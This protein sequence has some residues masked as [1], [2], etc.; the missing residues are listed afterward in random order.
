[1]NTPVRVSWRPSHLPDFG[2]VTVSADRGRLRDTGEVFA[3]HYTSPDGTDMVQVT[4][5][6]EQGFAAVVHLD[7]TLADATA[8]VGV[9]RGVI[10]DALTRSGRS[11]V[12]TAPVR[13][14]LAGSD[15]WTA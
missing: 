5:H 1:M 8:L 15:R 10:S 2:R 7:M 13:T 9:L 12:P 4:V 14:D 3:S 11:T 6:T